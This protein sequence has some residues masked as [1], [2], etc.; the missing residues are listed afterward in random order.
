MKFFPFLHNL[1]E[2]IQKGIIPKVLHNII[3]PQEK[4]WVTLSSGQLLLQAMSQV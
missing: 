2:F 3:K 1:R 4:L